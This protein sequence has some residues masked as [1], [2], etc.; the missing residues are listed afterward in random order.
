M[1]AVTTDVLVMTAE[2]KEN[3]IMLILPFIAWRAV[4]MWCLHQYLC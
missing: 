3:D 4:L 2:S 1:D